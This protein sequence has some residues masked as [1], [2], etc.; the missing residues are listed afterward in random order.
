MRRE[1]ILLI[2]S[3]RHLRVA[4]DALAATYPGCTIGVIG[5][6]G[7]EPAVAQAGIPPADYF[8]YSAPRIQPLALAFSGTARAARR[9]RYDRVAILWHD[10]QGPGQGNVDRAA[11]AL[12]PFG[13]LAV[14]PDGSIVERSSW[15][16]AI[17][18]C[19][20]L[21][22]SIGVGAALGML[23]FGPAKAGRRVRKA[24]SGFSRTGAT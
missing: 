18:E 13:Y 1:R 21:G 17:F 6:P 23:L 3:G 24:G 7:S 15:R 12:S 11:L 5:T 14:T 4:M 9:W 8:L 19:A 10:P 2:R 20:R 16:Q 22:A